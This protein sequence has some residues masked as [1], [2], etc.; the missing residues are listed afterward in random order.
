M[1]GA[2]VTVC[3]VFFCVWGCVPSIPF[4]TG[5]PIPEGQLSAVT[6]GRTTKQDLLELLGLPA[7]IVGQHEIAAIPSPLTWKGEP[8]TASEYRFQSDTFFEL[9]TP[10]NT[11]NEYHRIYYFEHVVSS[12]TG[13]FFLIA[14]YESGS[15]TA[16]RFWALVNERTG[17]VEEYVFKKHGRKAS[18]GRAP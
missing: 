10:E 18:I 1:T 15:T 2:V 12:Q 9:F 7:A 11:I 6:P 14:L 17:V 13:Y 3:L 8:F 5:D 4:T 16:D